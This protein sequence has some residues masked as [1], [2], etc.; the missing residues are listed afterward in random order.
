MT[1]PELI[2]LARRIA[3]SHGLAPTLVCAVCEQESAWD[4]SAI[5]YEPAFFDRYI[6][7]QNLQ[8]AT[9]ARA[10]AFSFG[11]MQVM[12]QVAREHGFKG[13]YLSE[14]LIPEVGLDFG[15]RVLKGKIATAGGDVHK[16]LLAY[17]GGGRP[18]YADEVFARF[19]KYQPTT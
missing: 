5:R 11:L 17:N 1:Q 14:L 19:A 13:K 8:N 2:A 9:E 12:G 18:E 10:R 16:G 3:T 7:K 6:V 4:T 15:C